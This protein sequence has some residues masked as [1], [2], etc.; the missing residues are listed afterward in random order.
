MTANTITDRNVLREEIA[1][2]RRTGL[3]YDLEEYTIGVCACGAYV[4]SV[5]G[6]VVSI[7]AVVTKEHWDEHREK[8][9]RRRRPCQGRRSGRP[10]HT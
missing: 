4:R 7:A 9:R 5:M 6:D 8:H 3:A 2:V 10:R 1:E